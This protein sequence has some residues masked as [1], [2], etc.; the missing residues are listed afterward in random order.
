MLEGLLVDDVDGA[1][2]SGEPLQTFQHPRPED[3]TYT[4]YVSGTQGSY[5]LDSYIYDKYGNVKFNENKG[6]LE[7]GEENVFFLKFDKEN[8]ENSRIKEQ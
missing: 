3:G 5:H 4:V 1:S 7:I 2:L 8:S 6:Y